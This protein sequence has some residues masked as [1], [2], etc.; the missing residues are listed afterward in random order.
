[1]IDQR[2]HYFGRFAVRYGAIRRRRVELELVTRGALA[3]HLDGLEAVTIA[4]RDVA[5]TTAHDLLTVR[6]LDA[7]GIQM[8]VVRKLQTAALA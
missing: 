6:R 1:M 8:F 3:L 4:C 7:F 5:I 2:L